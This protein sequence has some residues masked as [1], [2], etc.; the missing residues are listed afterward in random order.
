MR[1]KSFTGHRARETFRFTDPVPGSNNKEKL[2]LSGHDLEEYDA[3]APHPCSDSGA[4]SGSR[5]VHPAAFVL[6]AADVAIAGA[7][8]ANRA[9][10]AAACRPWTTAASR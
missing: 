1:M 3:G 9:L 4:S 2:M 6:V 10:L 5:P 7:L 8:A